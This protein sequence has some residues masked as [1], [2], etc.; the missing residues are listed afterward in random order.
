[1]LNFFIYEAKVALL[2][3]VFYICYRVLLSHE[4]FHRLNRIVLTGS[5]IVSFLLPFCVLTFHRTVMVPAD[6]AVSAMPSEPMPSVLP[7][8]PLDL[9]AVA[10][11]TAANAP[12]GGWL[13]T[14]LAF[15]YFSGVA[16]CLVRLVVELIQVSRLIRSGEIL[17]QQDGT[18]LVIVDRD[19]APFSW[20]RWTVLSRE[21]YE[22]GNRHI[23]QHERAHIRLGHAR[24]LLA[25]NVLSA[26]Q[27]FNP[28]MRMLKE[29]LRA[30]YEYEADDAVL[31]GGA[32]IRE[33]QYSLIRK[34]VSASGYS[35]TNSF[36]H[37]ILKNRITMMSK[38]KSGTWCGLRALY[39]LPLIAA[40]L[41]CNSRTVTNYEV[42]ENSQTK[43]AEMPV[44]SMDEVNLFVKQ[45]GDHVEYSVNDEKVSLEAVG[46]KVLEAQGEG[47]A[48]VNIIGDPAL[49]SGVIQ[50]VKDELRKVN[51][52]RIKYVSA[53]KVNV[54]RKLERMEAK[55]TLSD[56]PEIFGDGDVQ[57]RLND[58]DKLLYMRGGKDA[59]AVNQEDLF[60][61]AKEDVEKNPGIAF[62]FVIDNNSSYGPYSSAVQAVYNAF[63]TV[64]EDMATKT[65]GKPFDD[66]E[67]ARQDE[68]R[69]KCRVKITE[70]SK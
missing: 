26:M 15:I 13:L 35:I 39:V 47:F 58:S 42:G 69:E 50:Q 38:Q 57:I 28:V 56:L 33:Y 25:M 30:I 19:L 18:S 68:L 29:D 12:Q 21:D 34:A 67:E 20:M 27:W 49:K 64:R 70:I 44:F 36:N 1:M 4:T 16:F 46:E 62:F 66:L 52:F 53:P 48:Y 31:R 43:S 9:P 24:D 54:P 37:S 5:V 51:F 17:P 11:E 23:R 8:D 61:L 63:I 41:A 65:Y 32:N 45:A 22:S 3:A 14:L 10:V 2:L 59:R 40:A 6:A 60:A 55:K 7:Q